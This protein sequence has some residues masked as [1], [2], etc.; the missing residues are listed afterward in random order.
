MKDTES[1]DG[2]LDELGTPADMRATGMPATDPG[3]VDREVSDPHG[4][5]VPI[6]KEEY[7]GRRGG[8]RGVA[9]SLAYWF[10]LATLSIYGP[11]AQPR[12]ADPIER[13]KRKYGRPG[14]RY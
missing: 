13:L 10:Q 1:D 6:S 12:N 7:V 8:L 3:H 4:A 2:R 5:T 11:A 14:R 9:D